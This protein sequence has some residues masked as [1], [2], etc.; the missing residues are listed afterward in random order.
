LV[1]HHKFLLFWERELMDLAF[2]DVLAMIGSWSWNSLCS[3]FITLLFAKGC[4]CLWLMVDINGVVCWTG[5]FDR[6]EFAFG[7]PK[8]VLDCRIFYRYIIA[9]LGDVL[10]VRT[11]NEGLWSRRGFPTHGDHNSR[12]DQSSCTFGFYGL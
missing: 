3:I 4:W 2:V 7:S 5:S 9:V 12:L 6:F 1:F 8:W 10:L 11:G